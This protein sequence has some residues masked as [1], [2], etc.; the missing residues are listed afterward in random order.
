MS[1]KETLYLFLLVVGISIVST[2]IIYFSGHDRKKL[3]VA[4]IFHCIETK[5]CKAPIKGWKLTF[6]TLMEWRGGL[7]WSEEIITA[8]KGK[9]TRYFHTM[10]KIGVDPENDQ[11]VYEIRVKQV[12]TL[13]EDWNHNFN[14]DEGEWNGVKGHS[15]HYV[16]GW[17]STSSESSMCCMT[18]E[19]C[20]HPE[21]VK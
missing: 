14:W 13:D 6:D 9:E 1:N 2:T 20:F 10:V 18:R 8:K 16:D 12:S 21:A 11:S 19:Q 7:D 15:R 17:C 3:M 4:D 5:T